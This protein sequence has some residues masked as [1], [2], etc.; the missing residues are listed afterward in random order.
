MLG[1]RGWW[2]KVYGLREV[3]SHSEL[4][5]CC[6]DL[7]SFSTEIYECRGLNKLE[8]GFAVGNSLSPYISHIIPTPQVVKHP[9]APFGQSASNPV[10]Q[11]QRI[12]V[13]GCN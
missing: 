6:E 8:Y 10:V 11:L 12:A 1:C 4:R 3:S 13:T 7:Q 9:S 2:F 5:R